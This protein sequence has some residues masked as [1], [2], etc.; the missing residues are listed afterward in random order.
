MQLFK[1]NQILFLVLSSSHVQGLTDRVMKTMKNSKIKMDDLEMIYLSRNKVRA[2][3][4][5]IQLAPH[6]FKLSKSVVVAEPIVDFTHFLS[7]RLGK[8]GISNISAG[9][10]PDIN[11]SSNTKN[12][13]TLSRRETDANLL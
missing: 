1:E 8:G 13:M 9:L 6:L 10:G 3:E 7:S 11:I 5:C 4:D 12:N 2:F